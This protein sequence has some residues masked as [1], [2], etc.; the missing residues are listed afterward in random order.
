MPGPALMRI[1][2]SWRSMRLSHAKLLPPPAALHGVEAAHGAAPNFGPDPAQ[3]R[4]GSLPVCLRV[5]R[6]HGDGD[7]RGSV[8]IRFSL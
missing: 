5:R 6:G 8:L 4:V 2:F 3:V 1:A 7:G